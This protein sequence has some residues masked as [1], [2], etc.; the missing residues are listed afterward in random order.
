[1]S[2]TFPNF[3]TTLLLRRFFD[4]FLGTL[5]RKMTETADMIHSIK[6][7]PTAAIEAAA[8]RS[9]LNK[10]KK[11]KHQNSNNSNNSNN[12]DSHR[13]QHFTAMQ[14]INERVAL[15]TSTKQKTKQKTNLRTNL[16]AVNDQ[17]DSIAN[18]RSSPSKNII[19][20]PEERYRRYAGAVSLQTQWRGKQARIVYINQ[21]RERYVQILK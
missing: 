10:N 15:R 1:M 6:Q 13:Q 19:I 8:K 21:K 17:D 7:N 5:E 4:T 20:D 3:S 2:L 9:R 16:L 11:K 18:Y 14:P 12:S